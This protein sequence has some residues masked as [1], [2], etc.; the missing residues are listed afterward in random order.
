MFISSL[1]S[2]IQFEIERS[3][4]LKMT[5]G[6]RHLLLTVCVLVPAVMMLTKSLRMDGRDEHDHHLEMR[7]RADFHERGNN[8]ARDLRDYVHTTLLEGRGSDPAPP[9][10]AQ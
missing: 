7:R 8:F 6:E 2:V 10:P 4:V 1:F 9:P 3:S 5:L